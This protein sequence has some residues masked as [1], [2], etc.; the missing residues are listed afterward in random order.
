MSEFKQLKKY[1]LKYEFAKSILIGGKINDLIYLLP[2]YYDFLNIYYNY[3]KIY[4]P[5]LKTP[6]Q[7]R[8]IAKFPQLYKQK[9]DDLVS[10]LNNQDIDSIAGN[11][12]YVDTH[13]YHHDTVV[14]GK[15]QTCGDTVDLITYLLTIEGALW[16]SKIEPTEMSQIQSIFDTAEIFAK[17]PYTGKREMFKISLGFFDHTFYMEYIN[18]SVN[19]PTNLF[20][21][22]YKKEKENL[23]GWYIYQSWFNLKKFEIIFLSREEFQILCSFYAKLCMLNSP[24]IT[25]Q[26]QTKQ[27]DKIMAEFNFKKIFHTQNLKPSAY[28]RN[29][30]IQKVM[31]DDLVLFDRC[32]QIC[33]EYFSKTLF[34]R[35][36]SDNNNNS[37]INA[38][39][40]KFMIDLIATTDLDQEKK[41][42]LRQFINMVLLII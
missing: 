30:S 6:A 1:K 16:D 15:G 33:D 7:L 31:V 19:E 5:T 4:D 29:F 13:D 37:K 24:D 3:K 21:S 42:N 2:K 9:E 8:M 18:R 12:Q 11:I 41:S 17:Q 36:I 10:N 35:L 20:E 28:T 23:S 14:C 38:Q 39:Y 22:L 40:M 25:S 34:R 26:T 27:I 32:Y